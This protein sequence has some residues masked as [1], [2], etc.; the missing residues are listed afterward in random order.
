MKFQ[1]TN[2][3]P[4]QFFNTNGELVG[5]ILVDTA[6]TT[7]VRSFSVTRTPG[8]TKKAILFSP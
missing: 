1:I 5:T 7:L 2:S 8:E 4:I 3:E 6:G